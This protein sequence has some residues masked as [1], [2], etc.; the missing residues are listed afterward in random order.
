MEDYYIVIDIDNNYSYQDNK[1]NIIYFYNKYKE[2]LKD[3]NINDIITVK[4]L[5]NDNIDIFNIILNKNLIISYN[6]IYDNFISIK[7]YIEINFNHIIYLIIIIFHIFNNNKKYN[8]KILDYKTNYKIYNIND[9]INNKIIIRTGVI[10]LRLVNIMLYGDKNIIL[11]A[12][13]EIKNN[14]YNE[15]FIYIVNRDC[16]ISIYHNIK[17]YIYYIKCLMTNAGFY[18]NL[19]DNEDTI[20]EQLLYF[21][22]EYIKAIYD[23]D[24]IIEWP[25]LNCFSLDILNNMKKIKNIKHFKNINYYDY[26]KILNNKNILFLTPFKDDIDIIYKTEKIYNLRKTKCDNLTKINLITLE[27]KL[28]TYPNT[29]H[30]NFIETLDYYKQIINKVL[31]NNKIDVFISSCGCYGLLL[32]NYVKNKY[33]N[34]TV[35]Y[36]GHSINSFFGIL[37]NRNNNLDDLNIENHIFSKLNEN[38]KNIEKIENN[39]YG[40]K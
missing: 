19:N 27:A 28:T 33:K 8:D 37:S 32:S 16:W 2:E 14:Y 24:Y 29:F 3:K 1:I 23:T 34:I 20:Y 11:K 26:V 5:Y 13:N 7:E 30:N 21:S 36:N 35:I 18:F 9:D 4:S 6:I 39:C 10:E 25:F 15:D 17:N 38:Y 12:I 22:N 31:N 40:N